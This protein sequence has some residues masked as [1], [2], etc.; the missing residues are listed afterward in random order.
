MMPLLV[1]NFRARNLSPSM[2]STSMII[3]NF[4]LM[5][6]HFRTPTSMD[7]PARIGSEHNLFPVLEVLE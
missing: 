3:S 7:I 2:T 4:H 5:N 6:V 1:F